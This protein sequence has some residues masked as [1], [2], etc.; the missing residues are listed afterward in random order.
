MKNVKWCLAIGLLVGAAQVATVW[1][2]IL[3]ENFEGATFPPAGWSSVA[4]SGACWA[5]QGTGH[6]GSGGD[7]GSS[8]RLLDYGTGYAGVYSPAYDT[9]GLAAVGYDF[10][11]RADG[12]SLIFACDMQQ[13]T[14]KSGPYLNWDGGYV[15]Y[16][17]PSASAWNYVTMNWGADF[18]RWSTTTWQR[19]EVIKASDTT[20]KLSV[21]DMVSG[22]TQVSDSF[23]LS[24]LVPDDQMKWETNNGDGNYR[25][26]CDVDNVYTVPEPVSAVLLMSGMIPFL[27]SRRRNA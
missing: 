21:T 17:N 27:A 24:S 25:L 18:F 9:T 13:G 1:G 14:Q 5:G 3:N 16:L 26:I 4:S 15:L 19:V 20:A 11:Y 6:D 7:A 10:K 8:F 22:V 12:R 2:T 23:T